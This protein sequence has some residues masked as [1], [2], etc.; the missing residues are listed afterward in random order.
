MHVIDAYI[1]HTVGSY[2]TQ[3]HAVSPT[4]QGNDCTTHGI[5]LLLLEPRRQTAAGCIF[6]TRVCRAHRLPSSPSNSFATPPSEQPHQLF[7]RMPPCG[8]MLR[9]S[10]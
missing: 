1:T 5:D 9:A 2:P 8:C 10:Q 4:R 7:P 3:H 6:T